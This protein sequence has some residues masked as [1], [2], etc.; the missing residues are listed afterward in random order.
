MRKRRYKARDIMTTE[1]ECVRTGTNLRELERIFLEKGITGAPVIDADGKLLGV[2]S[3]TDLVFYHLTR[4]DQPTHDSDFYRAI[5][6]QQSFPAGGFQI[7]DYD[8]GLVDDVMTPVVHTAGP[9]TSVEYLAR[10]MIEKGI[11]RVIITKGGRVVGLVS[12]LDLLKVITGAG[13]V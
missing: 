7:E 12:A 3:Q 6:L 1:V 8:I 5:G 11:H 10:L 13:C 9:K 2:I 4:G